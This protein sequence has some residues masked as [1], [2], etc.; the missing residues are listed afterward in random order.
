MASNHCIIEIPDVKWLP[1]FTSTPKHLAAYDT[2]KTQTK[3][4]SA[5]SSDYAPN[6]RSKPCDG[7]CEAL[8]KFDSGVSLSSGSLENINGSFRSVDLG[9]TGSDGSAHDSAYG[10]SPQR[11]VYGI[12]ANLNEQD[13]LFQMLPR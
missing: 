13:R 10:G 11:F 2:K 5:I 6:K 8:L 3:P 1:V 7:A 9:N 4:A 12:E